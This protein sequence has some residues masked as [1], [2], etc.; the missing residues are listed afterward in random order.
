MTAVFIPAWA[1][2]VAKREGVAV[3]TSE[4]G[5]ALLFVGSGGVQRMIQ[6]RDG[7]LESAGWC[8]LNSGAMYPDQVRQLTGLPLQ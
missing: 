7:G 6:F 8:A 4:K 2:V 3:V 5:P 1:S